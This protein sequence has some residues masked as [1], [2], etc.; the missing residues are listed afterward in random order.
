[1]NISSWKIKN[2]KNWKKSSKSFGQFFSSHVFIEVWENTPICTSWWSSWVIVSTSRACWVVICS[3]DV[4]KTELPWLI[5]ACS[6]SICCGLT[7]YASCSIAKCLGWGRGILRS[8]RG[9][10]C[11]HVVNIST[12]VS[13]C[14]LT[15]WGTEWTSST[16]SSGWTSWSCECWKRAHLEI[17]IK[18]KK[19]RGYTKTNNPKYNYIIK[20]K[21]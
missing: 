17:I 2:W 3:I 9:A 10:A 7:S 12:A 8:N 11:S 21:L 18:N 14:A 4:W 15:T 6:Q 1:M 20:F 13:S 19:G 5:H 16:V